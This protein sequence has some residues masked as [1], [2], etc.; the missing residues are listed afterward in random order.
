[1]IFPWDYPIGMNTVFRSMSDLVADAEDLLARLSRSD[2][3]QVRALRAPVLQSIDQMKQKLRNRAKSK[4]IRQDA[5]RPRSYSH[6][7]HA[8]AAV[9][10]VAGVLVWLNTRNKVGS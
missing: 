4:P 10:L 8:S 9:F 2:D 6:W 5:D 7:M 3:A 1:V